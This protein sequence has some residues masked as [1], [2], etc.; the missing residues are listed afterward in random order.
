MSPN[1][2]YGVMA[3]LLAGLVVTSSIALYYYGQYG[4]EVQTEQQNASDLAS[5]TGQNGQLLQ[6][7]DSA[8]AISNQSLSL[9][10]G[11]V[12]VVNTS[13]PIYA[14]ASSQLP[15]LWSAFL[16]L[17]P[18]SVKLYTTDVLF[19]F[20]NGTRRWFNNTQ[21]Q[22]G[23]NLYTA[24]VVVT[25]GDMQTVWYPSFGE[26][27]VDSMFGVAGTE[28]NYWL[29]WTHNST[30][31]QQASVGADELPVTNGSVFAWTYCGST[32]EP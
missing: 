26:H 23:W 15:G 32:C 4:Q 19:N 12:G 30:A 5:A 20:G 28:T 2:T 6:Q 3:V 24:T 9:L 22:P 14:Q 17:K 29:V 21:V 18:E 8:V 10:A 1:T 13:L 31:W 16:K 27:L 25:G 11:T 7:Y